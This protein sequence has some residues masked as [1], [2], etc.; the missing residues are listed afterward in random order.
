[1]KM[2]LRVDSEMAKL[3]VRNIVAVT[4]PTSI[5][6]LKTHRTIWQCEINY[7]IA[8]WLARQPS[9]SY[10]VDGKFVKVGVSL[11]KMDMATAKILARRADVTRV[12]VHV[13]HAETAMIDNEEFGFSAFIGW[14][15]LKPIVVDQSPEEKAF[16]LLAKGVDLYYQFSD[17]PSVWRRGEARYRELIRDGRALGLSETAMDSIIRSM[18]A[19]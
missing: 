17:D 18:T 4:I 19:K 16:R 1:M 5:N 9:D 7:M 2:F 15:P 12:C 6:G 8:D 14:C 11:S 13:R 10:M 3:F